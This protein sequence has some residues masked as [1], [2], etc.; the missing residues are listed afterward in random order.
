MICRTFHKKLSWVLKYKLYPIPQEGC[1]SLPYEIF[2]I[3]HL[4]VTGSSLCQ[5]RFCG[6][7]QADVSFYTFQ[8][9]IFLGRQTIVSII[10]FLSP[11]CAQRYFLYMHVI[12]LDKNIFFHLLVTFMSDAGKN[13]SLQAC[14]FYWAISFMI[15]VILGSA[16]LAILCRLLS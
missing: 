9:F 7:R 16:K 6:R 3:L 5:L 15:S 4:S 10:L 8:S 14:I 13:L 2:S 1:F 12:H 11:F